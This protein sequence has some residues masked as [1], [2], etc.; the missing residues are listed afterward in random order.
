MHARQQAHPSRQRGISL[1]EALI[2]FLV[3]SLGALAMSRLQNH[4]RFN[5]DVARQRS[6][7]VR[8]AQED[9]EA[10]RTFASLTDIESGHSYSDILDSSTDVAPGAD[11]AGNTNF[12]VDR[13]IVDAK[14]FRTASVAVDWSDRNG[15]GQ[16][17]ILHSVIAA[18]PPALSGSLTLVAAAASIKP[19]LGR[20]PLIP[21]TAKDL[22][23]GSS[24]FKP[25]EALTLAFVFDNASGRITSRCDH[26]AADLRTADLGSARLIDCTPMNGMLLSGVV[27]V[28]LAMPPEAAHPAEMSL[29]LAVGIAFTGPVKPEAPV[30]ITD[31]SERAVAYHCVIAPA[32]GH[33][34]GRSALVPRGW[35]LGLTAADKKVCRYSADNDGSGAIDSNAE[36]PDDYKDVDR[37]LMQQ[38]FL[39]IRGDQPCPVAAKGEAVFADISTVQHQP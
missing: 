13:S 26:I 1:V 32:S 21:L 23:N 11:R 30:C 16:H 39:I 22:G 8:L 10:S 15:H 2:A 4:L 35:T 17:V 36:H 19:V 29:P 37:S 24:A 14:G 12:H 6:E 5:A 9:L 7:A 38:N 25:S 18:T 34:S 33:W 28:S 27:R 20:S 31:Q 3:L